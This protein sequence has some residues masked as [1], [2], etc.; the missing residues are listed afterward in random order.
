MDVGRLGLVEEAGRRGLDQDRGVVVAG[1]GHVPVRLAE[2][3]HLRLGGKVRQLFQR[4]LKSRRCN[5][6]N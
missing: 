5:E 6:A 1:E 2:V 4:L 3:D